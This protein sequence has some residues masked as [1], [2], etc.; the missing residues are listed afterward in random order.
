MKFGLIAGVLV[1]GLAGF[2]ARHLG[3]FHRGATSVNARFDYWRAAVQ[4]TKEHPILGTG[5]GTFFIAYERVRNTNSEPARLT[6]NDY[7]EQASDSGIPGLLLYAGFV[8]GS[9][10]WIARRK[11]F[12][13]DW[14]N[15]AIWLGVLGWA[16]QSLV[17]FALYI[18]A[19]SWSAF[20]F[21]GLMVG[22][23]KS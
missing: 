10:A 19:L 15:F 8:V 7:L 9:L 20:A 22:K 21:L 12:L 13:S 6:H 1:I 16:L 18:P 14:R 2:F 23:A 11:D 4:T 17:E 3:Y 5:P